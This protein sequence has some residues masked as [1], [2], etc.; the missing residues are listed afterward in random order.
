MSPSRDPSH[1]SVRPEDDPQ[2]ADE[3]YEV[4]VA[5][6]PL[7][8]SARQLLVGVGLATLVMFSTLFPSVNPWPIWAPYLAL[9]ALLVVVVVVQLV[10]RPF[11]FAAF[12]KWRRRL[13]F[14]VKG[15]AELVSADH[16][17]S[18]DHW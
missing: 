11:R 4:F 15:W 1:G 8:V 17:G 7:G 18:I 14:R 9:V 12:R 16:L 10:L 5:L 13:P 6:H 3:R 2:L